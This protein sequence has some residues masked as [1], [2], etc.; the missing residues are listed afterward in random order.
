MHA[1]DNFD[2]SERPVE[3]HYFHTAGQSELTFPA[4]PLS[5]EAMKGFEYQFERQTVNAPPG[6]TTSMT[7]QLQPL[8]FQP[9]PDSN[10]SAVTFTYT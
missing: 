10:G 8:T 6:R 3:A 1:D 5:V 2:R 4:G 7:I 9:M